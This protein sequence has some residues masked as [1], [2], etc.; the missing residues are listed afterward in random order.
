MDEGFWAREEREQLKR[1]IRAI[2][3]KVVMYYVKT[4]IEEIRERVIERNNNLTKE[5]FE[6]SREMLDS[7]L[8][9]WQPPG[10]DEHYLLA[11]ELK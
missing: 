3:A 10:E 4:S 5:S 7:Y 2:G 6:I 11:S 1:R 9:G 8:V